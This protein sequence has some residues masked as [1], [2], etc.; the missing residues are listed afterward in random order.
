[1]DK[2]DLQS[3]EASVI[4]GA[5]SDI[6]AVT[7]GHSYYDTTW[8]GKNTIRLIPID[9]TDSTLWKM[10]KSTG[11]F[12]KTLTTSPINPDWISVKI[13]GMKSGAISLGMT[14]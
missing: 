10:R 2:S 11:L 6:Y 14:G 12:C 9:N 7:L 5:V 1:M 4:P 3:L 8:T 13:E